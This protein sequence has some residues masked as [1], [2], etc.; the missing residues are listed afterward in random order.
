MTTIRKHTRRSRKT[1]TSEEI[2][3][4][5]CVGACEALRPYCTSALQ[6]AFDGRATR[7]ARPSK[8]ILGLGR[9][10][11]TSAGRASEIEQTVLLATANVKEAARALPLAGSRRAFYRPTSRHKLRVNTELF[12]SPSPK[13]P[14]ADSPI[15]SNPPTKNVL[16]RSLGRARSVWLIG[17]IV[18]RCAGAVRPPTSRRCGV[19]P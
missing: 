13:K 5:E 3:E 15:G 19:R 2:R 16:V 1:R 8:R 7:K 12:E 9:C 6:H 17:R 14:E 10:G 11:E 4:A 18:S